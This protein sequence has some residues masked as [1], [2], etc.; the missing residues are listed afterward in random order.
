MKS[1]CS[2]YPTASNGWQV[3]KSTSSCSM[4]GR[5]KKV[6]HRVGWAGA[7]FG[8]FAHLFIFVAVCGEPFPPSD[9]AKRQKEESVGLVG[10]ACRVARVFGVPLA[11][12]GLSFGVSPIRIFACCSASA[13]SILFGAYLWSKH[14]S[15]QIFYFHFFFL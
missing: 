14:R 12:R 9:V 15:F 13:A 10:T 1:R 5:Y 11:E 7:G 3:Q 8:C 4:A 6:R 2:N